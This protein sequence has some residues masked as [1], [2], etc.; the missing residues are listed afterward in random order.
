MPSS[1]RAIALHQIAIANQC[2]IPFQA[3]I[4]QGAAAGNN[5]LA[6]PN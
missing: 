4:P 6:I 5:P 1:A 3:A 2:L